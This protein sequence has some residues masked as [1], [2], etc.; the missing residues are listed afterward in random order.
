M[1]RRRCEEHGTDS[2]TAT[3]ITPVLG[4]E[5]ESTGFGPVIR[6]LLTINPFVNFKRWLRAHFVYWGSWLLLAVVAGV[7]T[8]LG[9]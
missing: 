9:S 4:V 3:V 1:G 6:C 5:V 8:A 2:A 7:V